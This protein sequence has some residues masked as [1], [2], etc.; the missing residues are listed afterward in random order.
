MA[1]KE[2]FLLHR[3]SLSW[4]IVVPA[5]RDTG[6]LGHFRIMQRSN[7]GFPGLNEKKRLSEL[8]REATMCLLMPP[9]EGLP[10][11]PCL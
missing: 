6:P 2:C 1:E 8:A 3:D 9:A 5:A 10:V 7:Q 4:C 11:L